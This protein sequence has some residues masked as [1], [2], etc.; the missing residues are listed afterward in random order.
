M[1]EKKLA[2][3]AALRE[4]KVTKFDF[5]GRPALAYRIGDR[6]VA[7][8]DACTHTGGPLEL[9]GDQL[10]C[11]WHGACFGADQGF[12][13]GGP[14]EAGSRL[15]LLPLEVRPDGTV[16]FVYNQPPAASAVPW[17]V[18]PRGAAEA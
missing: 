1:V 8:I 9:H 7:A 11:Q 5:F 15:T 13:C 6:P 4:D 16:W 14:A 12:A 2:D 18:A 10:R 17:P 3:L